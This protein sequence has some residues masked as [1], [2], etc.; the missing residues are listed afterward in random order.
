LNRPLTEALQAR[1][2]PRERRVTGLPE[3]HIVRLEEAVAKVA[4]E[5]HMA[6]LEA[7][8]ARAEALR[9]QQHQE[10]EAAA[11]RIAALEGHVATLRGTIAK[12]EALAEQRR[13]EVAAATKRADHL[14]AELFEVTSELVEMSMRMAEQAPATD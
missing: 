6:S 2:Q 4:R 9:E 3:V 10:A 7:A 11:E 5:A 13:Q 12:A 14:V 1:I 8:V